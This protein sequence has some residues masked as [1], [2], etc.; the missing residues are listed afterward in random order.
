MFESMLI[1]L[2]GSEM[3]EGVLPHAAALMQVFQSQVTLLRVME[4]GNAHSQDALVAPVDALDWQLRQAQA[5]RYLEGVGDRLQ[6]HSGAD[7]PGSGGDRI[8]TQVVDGSAAD[9]ILE[10]AFG[11][12]KD[13]IILGSHGQGGHS[14][15]HLNSVAQ[16]VVMRSAASVLVVRTHHDP[17]ALATTSTDALEHKYK[18]ILVP[19]DCSQRAEC[20]LPVA[21]N[22]ATHFGAQLVLVHVIRPPEISG[23]TPPSQQMLEMSAQFVEQN[24]REAELYLEGIKH[25]LPGFSEAHIVVG[26]NVSESLHQCVSEHAID[27]ILVSAHGHGGQPRWPHGTVTHH[28]LTYTD[29]PILV[30]QDMVYPCP[31]KGIN[32]AVPLD[33]TSYAL[34]TA[35]AHQRRESVMVGG[36]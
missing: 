27:L 1:P 31:R 6:A 10:W 4:T 9:A 11:H 28:L 33:Q 25:R 3:A 14:A 17:S 7:F 8:T 32:D 5:S 13:L 18:K 21:A 12:S 29:T 20:V 16:K 36:D 30:V 24:R 22:L 15:S 35:S 34:R 23:R 19:L 26:D 2:D